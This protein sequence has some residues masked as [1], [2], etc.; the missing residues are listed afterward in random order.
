MEDA[1]LKKRKLELKGAPTA[2]ALPKPVEPF[3]LQLEYEPEE[4][5]ESLSEREAR[6]CS[7]CKSGPGPGMET[8]ATCY[9]CHVRVH[10]SCYGIEDSSLPLFICARC[11]NEE[12][13]ESSIVRLLLFLKP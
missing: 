9:V 6:P 7:V 5:E 2:A 11:N 1:S 13:P 4:P 3:V 10:R 12:D 8:I